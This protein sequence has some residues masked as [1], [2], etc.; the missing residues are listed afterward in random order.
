MR[1]LQRK[2]FADKNLSYQQL[3]ILSQ[4]KRWL[5]LFSTIFFSFCHRNFN[6]KVSSR[7]T[8][9]KNVKMVKWIPDGST[10][11]TVEGNSV[12]HTDESGGGNVFNSLWDDGDGVTS[13]SHYWKIHFD[14]LESGGGVGLT[15]KD[16]FKEGFACRSLFY[17]GNLSTGSALLVPNFGDSPKAG[18]SV[19]IYALFAD[20]RLKVYIDLNGD[21]LGLAFDVP[22]S[23]FDAV[24]PMVSFNTSGSASCQKESEPPNNTTRSAT[25]VSGMEGEWK[26]KE[27]LQENDEPVSISSDLLS[28]LRT[29]LR[30]DGD[31]EYLWSTAVV[32]N[33]ITRLWSEDGTWKTAH[34]R[35][36][37]M[38][39]APE[40]MDVERRIT[41]LIEGLSSIGVNDDG[42]LSVKSEAL[43]SV[44]TRNDSAPSPF[45]GEPF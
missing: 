32:N 13:G 19:G 6:N 27:L 9:K 23:T 34:V 43:S 36:T 30:K 3:G 5:V 31:N 2:Y 26:L 1:K 21:S 33:L 18:D 44:W 35:S 8:T 7:N 17:S 14:S 15:S 10:G 39:A 45:V 29:K 25:T 24:Y 42:D 37:R 16:R 22:A 20:D 28:T 12:T 11:F 38:S 40:Y 4:N 41:S